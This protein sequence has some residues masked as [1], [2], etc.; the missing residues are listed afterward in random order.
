M[1]LLFG[2]GCQTSIT[3]SQMAREKSISVLEKLSGE[4]WKRQSTSGVLG[5]IGLD[6]RCALHG[7]IGDTV[8]IHLEHPLPLDRGRGV[9]QVDDGA[10]DAHQ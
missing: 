8:A 2:V 3:A 5:R 4:Y 10:L 6:P 9:V 1:H 7:D